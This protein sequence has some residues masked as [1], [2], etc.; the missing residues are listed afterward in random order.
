MK[1]LLL[2]TFLFAVL[3]VN[4]QKQFAAKGL[5]IEIDNK[6]RITSFYGDKEYLPTGAESFLLRVN[7][8]GVD[9]FPVSLKWKG[10]VGTA[11]FP[12]K[13]KGEF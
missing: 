3:G 2:I 8:N 11:L 12:E 10:N 9:C 13:V 4:A 6:G 7:I 1:K 5:K